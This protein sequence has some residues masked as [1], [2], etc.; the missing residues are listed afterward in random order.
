M[1]SNDGIVSYFR[2]VISVFSSSKLSQL[3]QKSSETQG[4]RPTTYEICGN[5][6]QGLWLIDLPV[7][8][9]VGPLPALS[10]TPTVHSSP[11][12][13]QVSTRDFVTHKQW[14]EL[15]TNVSHAMR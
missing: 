14:S 5:F 15:Q 4:D 8:H 13:P 2:V 1:D 3:I 12:L 7:S 9:H 6:H 10:Y 11:C